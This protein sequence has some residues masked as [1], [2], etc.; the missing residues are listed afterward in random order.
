M[1]VGKSEVL[2]SDPFDK[3]ASAVNDLRIKLDSKPRQLLVVDVKDK[4]SLVHYFEVCVPMQ[5]Y[6]TNILLVDSCIV[7][8]LFF[9]V[10]IFF[11]LHIRKYC[12]LDV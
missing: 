4:D 6:Q 5:N 2:Q 8:I 1:P 3:K 12:N 9:D 10:E 11:N 7:L